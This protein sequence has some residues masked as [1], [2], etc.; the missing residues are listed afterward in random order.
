MPV[1]ADCNGYFGSIGEADAHL[2]NPPVKEES[3]SHLTF[4]ELTRQ[5]EETYE[6]DRDYLICFQDL[7]PSDQKK[8]N[9]LRAQRQK[10]VT[11]S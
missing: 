9:E 5:M 2:C 3:S 8:Y 4:S 10:L 6:A 7:L 1:C 11:A